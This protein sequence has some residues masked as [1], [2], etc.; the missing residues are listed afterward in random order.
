[1]TT[2][3][4]SPSPAL[5]AATAHHADLRTRLTQLTETFIGA[6]AQGSSD[7]A[8][9]GEL[10]AFLRTELLPHAEVE[11]A[12]LYTAVRTDRTAL[13]VRAM[14]DEHRMIAA[15]I[16]EVEQATTPMDA[17]VAAG[18]LVVLCDVRIE[19]ENLH[20]LR[21]SRTRG[22]T[23]PGSSVGTPSLSGTPARVPHERRRLRRLQL[24]GVLPGE[25]AG[26]PAARGRAGGA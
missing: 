19:Q 7:P 20:L 16:D 9:G 11:D 14:Q 1:M 6:I 8:P 26:G 17:A 4:D 22:S 15:L 5:A 21:R 25:Y 3:L 12:L 2:T 10:V 23:W 24:P 18:A 13:L